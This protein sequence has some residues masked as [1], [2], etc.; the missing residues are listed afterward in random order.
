MTPFNALGFKGE[1]QNPYELESYLDFL[2]NERVTSYVE[3]GVYAGTT[4]LEVYKT[5]RE[6]HGPDVFL[7]M[8]AVERPSNHAA[9]NHLTS[10]VIPEIK[11]DPKVNLHLLVGGSTEPH[12]VEKAYEIIAKVDAPS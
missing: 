11:A 6:T 5:L 7:T 3:I 1:T 9:F 12:I 8:I 4:F 10:I 2:A